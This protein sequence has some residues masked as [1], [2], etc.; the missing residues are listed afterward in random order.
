MGRDRDPDELLTTVDV[1]KVLKVHHGT[2]SRWVKEGRLRAIRTPS[3]RLRIRR[4]DLEPFT[5]P[6]PTTEAAS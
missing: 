2:V 5:T 1:A 3:G 4:I 6:D